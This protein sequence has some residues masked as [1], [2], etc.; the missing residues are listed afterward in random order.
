MDDGDDGA[1]TENEIEP[2]CDEEQNCHDACQHRVDCLHALFAA[3]LG[4]DLVR[5][6]QPFDDARRLVEQ[7][8]IGDK[9][10]QRFADAIYRARVV[11]FFQ[12]HQHVGRGA[13]TFD[14]RSLEIAL[15]HRVAHGCDVNRVREPERQFR[16]ALE[17]NAV[18]DGLERQR[19]DDARGGNHQGDDVPE[20][21]LLDEINV[22]FFEKSHEVF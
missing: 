10:C 4:A 17:I 5:F 3:D 2:E 22:C 18:L 6:Q 7:G 15:I 14:F 16:A 20:P 13:V 11:G 8:V 9:F 1:H 21:A 19:G 12:A